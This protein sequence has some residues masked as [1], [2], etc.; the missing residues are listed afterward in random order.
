[1][2]PSKLLGKKKT[3]KQFHQYIKAHLIHWKKVRTCA[4][5]GRSL[6]FFSKQ[7]KKLEFLKY[8]FFFTLSAW[9]SVLECLDSFGHHWGNFCNWKDK[10][11]PNVSFLLKKKKQKSILVP[12][13][14]ITNN[15]FHT[16]TFDLWLVPCGKYSSS[17]WY[18]SARWA[19]SRM[20]LLG[21]SGPTKITRVICSRWSYSEKHRQT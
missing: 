12:L 1:M 13:L 3:E 2:S 6:Q 11:K 19:V 14:Q 7:I 5:S 8:M 18:C 15:R 9:E 17:S 20:V 10:N 4:Q 21:G 16:L